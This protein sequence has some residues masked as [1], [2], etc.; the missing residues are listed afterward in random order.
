MLF[1]N[2][3]D[4]LPI[5]IIFDDTPLEEV[6]NIKFLGVTVDN[7]LSW[8]FHIDNICKIISRNTGI[9]NRLKFYMPINILFTLYS[10]LVLPYLNYGILAWGNTHDTYLDRLLLLQKKCLRIICNTHH[11]SHTD[12]IYFENKILKVKDMYL[13]QLGQF[14]YNY[15]FNNL[16]QVFDSM[17]PQNSL[18]HKYPT[19]QSNEY[20]LP[21]LRTVRA[22]STFIYS[23]PKFWN[24]LKDDFKTAPSIYSFKIKLKTFLLQSYTPTHTS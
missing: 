13:Y 16:P 1:S 23:G 9:I 12:P 5:D 8:K 19:R 14:M 20:H 2:S 18:V 24:S 22:K 7:K 10:T 3:I 4:S 6:V 11:Y 21:L 15:H 17:F